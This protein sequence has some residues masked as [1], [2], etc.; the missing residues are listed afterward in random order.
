MEHREI[1]YEV[2]DG[3]ATITLNR[4]EQLNAFTFRMMDELLDVFDRTDADD[5][6][7]AVVVTGAGRAFCAGADLSAG[8]SA[9]DGS[10]TA[11]AGDDRHAIP[12]DGGGRV[13]LRIYESLKP[14]IAAINGPA[15][16][17]GITMTLPMDIRLVADDA[18]IGFVSTR[19]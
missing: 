7:G 11:E 19:A 6:V 13:A 15:V 18:R 12:R 10:A 16:G 1:L 4:P 5:G 8:V 3:V 9:F 14:V 17:V 2:T